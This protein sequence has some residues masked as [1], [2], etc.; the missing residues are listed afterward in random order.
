LFFKITIFF[1]VSKKNAKQILFGVKKKKFKENEKR[2]RF[3][4]LNKFI[5]R[6]TPSEPLNFLN[7]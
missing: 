2:L 1:E 5:E 3:L 4:K 6:L 7:I